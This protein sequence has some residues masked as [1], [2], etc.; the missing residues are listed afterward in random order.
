MK[1]SHA[2]MKPLHA[3]AR[4]ASRIKRHNQPYDMRIHNSKTKTLESLRFLADVKKDSIK[5]IESRNHALSADDKKRLMA[6][7]AEVRDY[8]K[9]IASDAKYLKRNEN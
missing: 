3:A 1:I 4:I 5:D 7:K 9:Q 8:E 6:L 2:L